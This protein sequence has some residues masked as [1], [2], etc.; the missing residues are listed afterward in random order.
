MG[1]SED[2]GRPQK[3]IGIATAG[4]LKTQVGSII[5]SNLFP[6]PF[7]QIGECRIPNDP[8]KKKLCVVRVSQ[9]P[10]ICLL[11]KK[12]EKHPVYVRVEDQSLPADAFQLRSL[13]NRRSEEQQRA[14]DSSL[15]L[16]ELEEQLAI[17]RY[18]ALPQGS[19]SETYFQVAICPA[20]S[21]Y[22]P[23]DLAMERSVASLITHQ[24]PGL[25]YLARMGQARIEFGRS[26][27]WFEMQFI[28]KS[29]DYE[30]RWRV[31]ARGDIGFITQVRWPV[32]GVG[33]CWSLYDVVTDVIRIL[34]IARQFW[35]VTRY[36]G[37]FRLRATLSVSG[38]DFGTQYN[39]LEPLF[40]NRIS[41]DLL[42][43]P[44]DPKAIRLVKKPLS[45][46]STERE[47]EYPAVAESLSDSVTL[48]VNQLVRGLGHIADVPALKNCVTGLITGVQN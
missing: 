21:Q 41:D 25:E 1:I 38:L 5:A 3:I 45:V 4:E 48:L 10:E 40:Y 20:D 12:G 36:Y 18:Q 6:S 8:D 46:T 15:R 37:T 9:S 24:N 34:V 17:F 14:T 28:D 22:V 2:D 43:F 26:R 13:L 47:F 33:Q 31:T 7:F 29:H 11:A 27:D 35:L 32:Q 19:R 44:L 23:F 39:A 42:H 30:R 16:R